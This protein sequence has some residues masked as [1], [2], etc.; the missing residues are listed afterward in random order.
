MIRRPPRSTRTDTLFPYT[1]LFRS[2]GEPLRT[3]DFLAG[4]LQQHIAGANTGTG[5][6]TVADA[7]HGDAAAEHLCLAALI[8]I[9]APYRQPERPDRCRLRWLQIILRDARRERTDIDLDRQ[10]LAVTQQLERCHLAW[11]GDTDH[12][13]Q[14]RGTRQYVTVVAEDDVALAHAGFGRRTLGDHARHHSALGSAQ[15]PL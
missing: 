6:G 7:D 12:R 10:L 13:R 1:T 9:H 8:G 11:I 2:F 15:L 14:C 5:A 4:N 3:V